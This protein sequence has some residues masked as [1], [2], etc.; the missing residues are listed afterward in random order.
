MLHRLKFKNFLTYRVK[1]ASY[2]EIAIFITIVAFV[3]SSIVAIALGSVKRYKSDKTLHNSQ[4]IKTALTNYFK[5]NNRMP[6][7]AKFNGSDGSFSSDLSEDC[8]GARSYI[9]SLNGLGYSDSSSL[10]PAGLPASMLAPTL[11]DVDVNSAT[12]NS[13]EVL[14]GKVPAKTLG[15]EMEDVVDGFDNY[16]TYYVIKSFTI[17]G[18]RYFRDVNI[19]NKILSTGASGSGGIGGGGISGSNVVNLYTPS[20]VSGSAFNPF[21][22]AS[23]KTRGLLVPDLGLLGEAPDLTTYPNAKLMSSAASSTVSF[24]DDIDGFLRVVEQKNSFECNQDLNHQNLKDYN[25]FDSSYSSISCNKANLVASDV[26][27]VLVSHGKDKICGYS[28]KEKAFNPIPQNFYLTQPTSGTSSNPVFKQDYKSFFFNDYQNCPESKTLGLGFGMYMGS[29]TTDATLLDKKANAYLQ[30]ASFVH[31]DPSR[32]TIQGLTAEEKA[33]IDSSNI[34]NQSNPSLQVSQNNTS[35]IASNLNET[36]QSNDTLTY[37]RLSEITNHIQSSGMID[38]PGVVVLPDQKAINKGYVQDNFYG[39]PRSV[40]DN[41]GWFSRKQKITPYAQK[42]QD[43]SLGLGAG[44]KFTELS[45]PYAFCNQNGEWF[46]DN[47]LACNTSGGNISVTLD[48]PP[49]GTSV[50]MTKATSNILQPSS[51]LRPS[52]RYDHTMQTIG[53]N[54]YMFGGRR[55]SFRHT[56]YTTDKTTGEKKTYENDISNEKIFNTFSPNYKDFD[57]NGNLTVDTKVIDSNNIRESIRA[58]ALLKKM[59]DYDTSYHNFFI[60]NRLSAGY[61]GYVFNTA[62]PGDRTTLNSFNYNMSESSPFFEAFNELWRMSPTENLWNSFTWVEIIPSSSVIPTARHSHSSA[63]DSSGD[64]LYIF[65]GISPVGNGKLISCIGPDGP[66]GDQSSFSTAPS[67]SGKFSSSTPWSMRYPVYKPINHRLAFYPL[68]I[69]I[70]PAIPNCNPIIEITKG[71][72]LT[73]NDFGSPDECP[74]RPATTYPD[75]TYTLGSMFSSEGV[76]SGLLKAGYTTEQCLS[77]VH[78]SQKY[79]LLNDL[80]QYN[81]SSNSWTKLSDGVGPFIRQNA[82]LFYFSNYIFVFGGIGYDQTSLNDLWAFNLTTKKWTKLDSINRGFANK[83]KAY[84]YGNKAYISPANGSNIIFVFDFTTMKWS[85]IVANALPTYSNIDYKDTVTQNGIYPKLGLMQNDTSQKTCSTF[86]NYYKDPITGNGACLNLG[87]TDPAACLTLIKYDS[88]AFSRESIRTGSICKPGDSLY[89]TTW[90]LDLK[91][92][93]GSYGS[94]SRVLGDTLL[95]SKPFNASNGTTGK[96]QARQNFIN[97]GLF[98]SGYTNLEAMSLL[99]NAGGIAM[100]SLTNAFLNTPKSYKQIYTPFLNNNTL[101]SYN[102]FDMIG[103]GDNLL[104]FNSGVT[105]FSYLAFP[106][107]NL[108]GR[109]FINPDVYSGKL[110]NLNLTSNTLTEISAIKNDLPG[111]RNYW[112]D[113]KIY[114]TNIF[115]AQE[116]YLQK[117]ISYPA[118]DK[119]PGR[120]NAT[121]LAGAGLSNYYISHPYMAYAE[122]S[123]PKYCVRTAFSTLT[124]DPEYGDVNFG[125]QRTDPN[126]PFGDNIKKMITTTFTK[127]LEG[128]KFSDTD[129]NMSTINASNLSGNS[130]AAVRLPDSIDQN[131]NSKQVF[132]IYSFGGYYINENISFG[133]AGNFGNDSNIKDI[134]YSYNPS[135]G[136][137]SFSIVTHNDIYEINTK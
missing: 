12:S 122:C 37:L 18:I 99:T 92:P 10:N 16:F 113:K 100:S 118:L 24:N 83:T 2:L 44:T 27:F 47:Q 53:N 35:G 109:Y 134:V 132:K 110:Y 81:L 14:Y 87:L 96:T 85:S 114:A 89:S 15:L 45:S 112:I 131:G 88:T 125:N 123:T 98:M 104:I 62:V 60:Y 71:S 38:C 93:I 40:F 4:N 84:V 76:H 73:I 9:V 46:T 39:Y 120:T 11:V 57:S 80:W 25:N 82:A 77:A 26:I 17:G 41:G 90:N 8:S 72:P 32:K 36:E 124:I 33:S 29:L 128:K 54:I 3:T 65:G 31:F 101:N 61:Q 137:M 51:V 94:V 133:I 130:F 21:N 19:A 50:Q 63:T 43:C 59:Y 56:S 1:A 69:N 70:L 66:D 22:P 102:Q 67:P 86:N 48:S 64:N 95:F 23:G 34:A 79:S 108:F 117:Y 91:F 103:Y 135:F 5:N 105:M 74:F 129:I 136:L 121:A 75:N 107:T 115:N 119:T 42:Y 13:I 126:G 116:A 20:G 49:F 97:S 7:P 55:H 106:R 52:P 78:G 30:S 58:G 28:A 68:S 111:P 6:C 127:Y